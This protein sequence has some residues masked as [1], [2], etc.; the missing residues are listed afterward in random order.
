MYIVLSHSVCGTLLQLPWG[1]NTI[2]KQ[3]TEHGQEYFPYLCLK[4]NLYLMPM[5]FGISTFRNTVE[6][7]FDSDSKLSLGMLA[8]IA[9]VICHL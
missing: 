7:S 6:K 8:K 1:M 3:S 2:T 4:S 5:N 9:G